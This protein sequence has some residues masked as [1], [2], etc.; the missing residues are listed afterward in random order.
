VRWGA[1]RKGRQNAP[2]SLSYSEKGNT[3]KVAEWVGLHPD[4]LGWKFLI[5]REN[6]ERHLG[7]PTGKSKQVIGDNMEEAQALGYDASSARSPL[8]VNKRKAEAAARDEAWPKK[9]C[10]VKGA[11]NF[12]EFLVQGG[13]MPFGIPRTF[14]QPR[15]APP[16][17]VRVAK[18]EVHARATSLSEAPQ[19]AARVGETREAKALQVIGQT[20]SLQGRSEAQETPQSKSERTTEVVDLDPSSRESKSEV[21][22]RTSLRE[23]DY[24]V[25]AIPLAYTAPA[26]ALLALPRA[27]EDE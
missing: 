20:V 27:Q 14:A 9:L 23:E 8:Q 5:S 11:G 26:R 15:A 10:H 1:L 7:Y 21:G 18:G 13:K 16:L 25:V 12:E 6:L 4:K 3:G 2:S 19:R 22:N 24:V 17:K